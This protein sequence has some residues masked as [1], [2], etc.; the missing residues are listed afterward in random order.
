VSR[1]VTAGFGAVVEQRAVSGHV[2]RDVPQVV[3]VLHM[4]P[5]L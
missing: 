4:P 1:F 3:P 2:S 5:G